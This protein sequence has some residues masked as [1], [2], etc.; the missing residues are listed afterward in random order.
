MTRID[1]LGS[2]DHVHY[3]II[4]QIPKLYYSFNDPRPRSF[5]Q[6]ITCVLIAHVNILSYRGSMLGLLAALSSSREAHCSRRRSLAIL[7][8]PSSASPSPSVGQ[9][10]WLRQRNVLVK[11]APSVQ[12]EK[13]QIL[14]QSCLVSV[15]AVFYWQHVF[16]V[17]N[18]TVNHLSMHQC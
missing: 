5:Q 4:D 8:T 13:D 10:I 15:I 17:N 16:C 2:E 3:C 1:K 12:E 7:M 9:G 11:S 6:T 18:V 14:N